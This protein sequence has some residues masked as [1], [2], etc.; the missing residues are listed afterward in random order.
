MQL[1]GCIVA[2]IQT[3]V[4]L[5]RENIVYS[6]H[7]RGERDCRKVG[8]L[9]ESDNLSRCCVKLT[10]VCRSVGG[11]NQMVLLLETK[12]MVV[13]LTLVHYIWCGN[14]KVAIRGNTIRIG[15]RACVFGI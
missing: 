10:T 2:G 4:P 14:V 3:R 13:E 12:L 7:Y 6:I 9:P 8:R 15:A 5:S 1:A 11:Q